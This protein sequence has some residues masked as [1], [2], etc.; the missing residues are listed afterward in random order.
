M[1]RESII[2]RTESG[3]SSILMTRNKKV[4]KHRPHPLTKRVD[5]LERTCREQ[6]GLVFE[7]I[8]A[9]M[10]PPRS[11]RKEAGFLADIPKKGRATKKHKRL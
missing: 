6:F 4:R 10:R 5:E 11:K 9:L 7:A 3:K 2:V 1:T 8:Q